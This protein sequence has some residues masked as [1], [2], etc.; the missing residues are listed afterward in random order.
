M[1]ITSDIANGRKA[2]I[3]G[4]VSGQWA[5]RRLFWQAFLELFGRLQKAVEKKAD[6]LS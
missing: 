6:L 1:S 4:R 5:D 3:P 2:K